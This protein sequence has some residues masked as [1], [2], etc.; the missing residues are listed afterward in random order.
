MPAAR[1]P[2]WGPLISWVTVLLELSHPLAVQAESICNDLNGDEKCAASGG[3]TIEVKM[4]ELQLS[5]KESESNQFTPKFKAE[6]ADSSW[7]TSHVYDFVLRDIDRCDF[8]KID[9]RDLILEENMNQEG[10]SDSNP[11]RHLRGSIHPDSL[12]WDQPIVFTNYDGN[13]EIVELTKRK[14]MLEDYGGKKVIL[15]NSITYSHD[16]RETSFR[17][18]VRAILI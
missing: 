9:Y 16:K 11:P 5:Q 4:P 15:S 13:R 14:R 10:Y 8:L 3:T 6:S 12:D 1:I 2:H 17:E 7:D 18:Y